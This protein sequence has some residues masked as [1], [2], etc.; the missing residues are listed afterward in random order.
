MSVSRDIRV[1]LI[2]AGYVS[3]YHI[4]ALQT[5]SHVRIVGI[6]DACQN[7][8]DALA[9]RFGIP[10]AFASLSDMRD[11]HPDVVHVLTP[12]ASHARLAVEALE[13]GC[14]V[15]VEKPMAPTVAECDE[16]IAAAGRTGRTLSVNHSAKDDPVVV[17]A[18]EMLRRGVCG[19]VLAVDFYRTSDYSPYAGGA[20]PDAFRR[21]GYPFQDMGVHA[22]YLMEAFLGPIRSLEVNFRSTGKEPDLFFDE[23]RGSV[24][25]AKGIGAFFLSWSARPIRNELFVHGTSG[26]MHIDC[27]LQ[28]C[29]VRKSLPGPKPIAAGINAMTEAARTLWHVP[30]NVWRL[31]TGSLRPSPGIHA[32]VLRFHHS[33]ARDAEPPVTMF[34]G[35]RMVAWLEPFSR[36]A[37]IRRDTALRPTEWLEPR[38]ILITG[39][40][41]L[42]GRALLDR[43]RASGESIRVL[44]RRR[45]PGLEELPGVQVVYGNLGDP[46][47]VDRAV[48]GVQLVYHVGA[49]MRGR[50]WAD[51]DAG[52]VSGTTNIV[53]S[54]LKHNVDRLVYVSSV[55]VLDYAGQPPHAVVDENA[56]LE[57][58]PE[59]RGFYTRSKLLAERNIV[60]A[61]RRGLRAVVLRPG[62]IVGPGY[63]SVSPYGT[64]ALAGRWIAIGSGRLKLPLVHVNDVIEGMIAAATR[65]NVCGAIFHL[66]DSTPVTQRD[67]ITRCQEEACG[68]IRAS[69]VPR[70][71]L[72]TAAAA[73]DLVG[74]LLKWN[75]PLTR[76]R[77]QSIKE[78]TFDCSAA[79]RQLGW[80]PMTGV[81]CERS[82]A[83][84]GT[85]RT[86]FAAAD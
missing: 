67:Y 32:G 7:R 82:T 73:L 74:T 20:L 56:P 15:F 59:K 47:A 29:T 63:E 71:M 54:C 62:Q 31:A 49:T 16:M 3:A 13:M 44:V 42:L 55:T 85:A 30:K 22:L 23:W 75:L 27:F 18:L 37:D 19:D 9:R 57:P 72:L 4:R 86:T 40:S 61:S 80:E 48:A 45:S 76:Y 84:Q 26:D 58:H 81:S 60:D 77:V 38:K 24:A 35:R 21:G 52:T 10:G 17:R 50:G 78:L 12:P 25:C 65:P 11:L 66:V 5:L 69:Y 43:L 33:L 64:L 68:S 2:G 39:A 79:R 51:F 34:E 46:E 41:G 8:A 14:H 1:A 70:T 6:A 36:E 53:R 83:L 28:T